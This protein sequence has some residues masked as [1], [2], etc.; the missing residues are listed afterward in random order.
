MSNHDLLLDETLDLNKSKQY[1][2]SILFEK[3]GL[4]FIILDTNVDKIIAYKYSKIEVVDNQKEYCYFIN[5]ILNSEEFVKYEYKN[6]YLLYP[7][8]RSILVPD[9]FYSEDRK[10]DLFELNLHLDKED[11]LLTTPIPSINS[12][13]IF[14]VPTCMA[15]LIQNYFDV[16]RVYHQSTPLIHKY[17]KEKNTDA[18]ILNIHQD[19]FDIQV[20]KDKKL[21]LD[22]AFKYQTKEDFLYY[23][24]FALEQLS[25]EAI[26]QKIIVYADMNQHFKLVNFSKKYFGAFDLASQPKAYNYSYL[27]SKEDINKTL[28]QISVFEC[29]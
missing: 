18:I 9:N 1:K 25:L 14:T 19:Y 15:D 29:E 6:I 17:V 26:N 7:S 10:K 3:N 23:L 24:L 2:L 11:T 21:L 22:N 16:S 20:V 27:F 4:S 8:F 28:A 12:K 13:K 5:K